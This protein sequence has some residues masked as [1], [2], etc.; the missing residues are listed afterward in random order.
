MCSHCNQG[1]YDESERDHGQH[2]EDSGSD[3][4]SLLQRTAGLICEALEKSGKPAQGTTNQE[5]EVHEG[6]V[7]R[8]DAELSVAELLRQR[9]ELRK[10][11]RQSQANS[12][13][14]IGALRENLEQR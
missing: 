8:Y 3:F 5:A 12:K 13:M 10:Q 7:G 4:A 14:L 6:L 9:D 1:N 11:I 2:G